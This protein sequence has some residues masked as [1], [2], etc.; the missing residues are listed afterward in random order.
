MTRESAAD[1]AEIA[2]FEAMADRWWDPRGPARPLHMLN[3][4]R[5]DYITDQ[6]AAEFDRDR[7]ARAPFAGLEICD[8]GCG[9]GLLSEPMARLGAAVTGIDAG[10]ESVAVARRHAAQQGLGIA[11]RTTTAEAL[12]DEGARFDVVL[13]SEIIEHVPDPRAFVAACAALLHPGGVLFVTTLNRTVRSYAAAII[14]AERVLRWLPP[15]THDWHRF[16][17]PDELAGL[18]RGAGLDPLDRKGFVPNPLEGAWRISARDLSVN[19]A[20]L[21]RRPVQA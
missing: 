7:R 18:M 10:A 4:C 17:T 8:V 15:G 19:Y 11:Y 5:L 9:G 2:R 1:A 16:L 12:A 13:A 14:G 6:L 21:A 20:L 3:P